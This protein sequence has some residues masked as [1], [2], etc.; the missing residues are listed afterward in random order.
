MVGEWLGGCFVSFPWIQNITKLLIL[1]FIFVCIPVVFWVAANSYKK[2]ITEYIWINEFWCYTCICNP[3]WKKLNSW[4]KR[5]SAAC[6]NAA[7]MI[8]SPQA[9]WTIPWRSWGSGLG[10]RI[11]S[12]VWLGRS[13]GLM[14]WN[15]PTKPSNHA[16]WLHRYLRSIQSLSRLTPAVIN[17][18]HQHKDLVSEMPYSFKPCTF[19]LVLTVER[20][21]KGPGVF[22]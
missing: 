6:L 15:G 17:R 2:M 7:I 12:R 1:F 3:L 9:G 11:W 16:D 20:F 8:L 18:R 10:L 4:S 22:S 19:C 14:I 21:V 13:P 5:N